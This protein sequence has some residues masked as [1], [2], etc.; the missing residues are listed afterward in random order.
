MDVIFE[1]PPYACLNDVVPCQAG[2]QLTYEWTDDPMRSNEPYI[3][4]TQ[5]IYTFMRSNWCSMNWGIR[6]DCRT[7]TTT[8]TILV[9]MER[10]L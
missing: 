7:S 9:F 3:R 1:N 2:D 5:G 6:W 10:Q 8:W 4:Q